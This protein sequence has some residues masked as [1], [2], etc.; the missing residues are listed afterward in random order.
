MY[1]HR[2]FVGGDGLV[3]AFIFSIIILLCGLAVVIIGL[4]RIPTCANS[5]ILCD[6]GTDKQFDKTDCAFWGCDK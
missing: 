5:S 1:N 2:K 3:I 6:S 4:I